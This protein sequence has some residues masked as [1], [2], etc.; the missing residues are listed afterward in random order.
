MRR[1]ERIGV[2]VAAFFVVLG[3]LAAPSASAQEKKPNILVI[4]MGD[5]IGWF[6]LGAYHGGIMLNATPN[7]DK[8]ATEGMRLTDYY[9]RSK[10]HSRS[11]QLHHWGITD[12]Y[13]TDNCRSGWL[14]AGISRCGALDRGCVEVYGLGDLNPTLPCLHEFDE[15]SACKASDLIPSALYVSS[16]Y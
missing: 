14:G 10:L 8:L 1:V 6:N 12:T 2:V 11:R 4:M 13:W 7:L 3:L 16:N 15:Y 9:N 5:H